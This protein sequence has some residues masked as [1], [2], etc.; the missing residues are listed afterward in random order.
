M[1]FL[2]LEAQIDKWLVEDMPY[3]DITTDLL[4][5]GDKSTRAEVRAKAEGVIAGLEV[6]KAVFFE[7]ESEF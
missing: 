5:I 4:D 1:K 3:M 7:S 6:F 2:G